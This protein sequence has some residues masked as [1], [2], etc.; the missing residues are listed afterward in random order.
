MSASSRSKKSSDR[1]QKARHFRKQYEIPT[2]INKSV[3]EL[4]VDSLEMGYEPGAINDY[5]VVIKRRERK[6]K[7]EIVADEEAEEV[8][9]E[10]AKDEEKKQEVTQTN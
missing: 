3:G 9:E 8:K 4:N 2:N 5:N 6:K 7:K 1:S 10:K